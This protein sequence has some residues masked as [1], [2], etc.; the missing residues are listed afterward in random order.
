MLSLLF[1]CFSLR[2]NQSWDDLK[3]SVRS[4]LMKIY[5]R[6]FFPKHK[7]KIKIESAF[8][9]HQKHALC[10]YEKSARN[11]SSIKIFQSRKLNVFTWIWL[12]GYVIGG[13]EGG[14]EEKFIFLTSNQKS[15]FE[16]W[17]NFN[18]KPFKSIFGGFLLHES[19]SLI[20]YFTQTQKIFFEYRIG[21]QMIYNLPRE[22]IW[23]CSKPRDSF[24]VNFLWYHVILCFMSMNLCGKDFILNRSQ[25]MW[26]V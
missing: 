15:Y 11:L 17:E 14:G 22:A 21:R 4:Q 3:I 26:V 9:F 18:Y 20:I 1:S 25:M 19:R 23:F 2:Q 5:F 24:N 16:S 12:K 6:C 10:V 13:W 7:R 8:P